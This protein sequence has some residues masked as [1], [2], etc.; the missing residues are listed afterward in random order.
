M[1][2]T[3]LKSNTRKLA[4]RTKKLNGRSRSGSNS[5]AKEILRKASRSSNRSK[6]SRSSSRSRNSGK[7]SKFRGPQKKLMSKVSSGDSELNQ[8]KSNRH[9]NLTS[10][11]KNS[12]SLRKVKVTIGGDTSRN[13]TQNRPIKSGFNLG[14]LRK[15]SKKW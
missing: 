10:F 11:S 6:N 3:K 7:H 5:K 12:M 9:A 2:G 14:N 1:T 8:L 15:Q 4:S 13:I